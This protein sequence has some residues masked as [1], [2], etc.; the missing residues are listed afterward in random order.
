MRASY[1]VTSPV[2]DPGAGDGEL[3]VRAVGRQRGQLRLLGGRD[4][5]V[6]PGLHGDPRALV[7]TP[8]V[9]RQPAGRVLVSLGLVVVGVDPDQGAG[10]LE[11]VEVADPSGLGPAPGARHP[12][13]LDR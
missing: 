7:A 2:V 10:V 8:A 13:V 1:A 12:R 4:A 3:R 5:E 6:P 9:S 11:V